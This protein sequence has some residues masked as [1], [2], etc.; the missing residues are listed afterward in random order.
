MVVYSSPRVSCK[1]FPS[2]T[3]ILEFAG[4]RKERIMKLCAQSAR[5]LGMLHSTLPPSEGNPESEASA[6][7]T[8]SQNIESYSRV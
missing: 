8:G 3:I 6:G 5:F 1:L 4:S 2:N 7:R